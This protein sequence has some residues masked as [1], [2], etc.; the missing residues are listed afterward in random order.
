MIADIDFDSQGGTARCLNLGGRT[1][2]SHVL[3]LGLEF[4][5]RVQVEVGY[6]DFGT[7][8]GEPLRVSPSET[9]RRTRDDRHLPVQLSHGLAS[10]TILRALC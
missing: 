8:S 6:R 9:S 10:D 1:L 7:Q 2:G 5:I 4:L 3:R